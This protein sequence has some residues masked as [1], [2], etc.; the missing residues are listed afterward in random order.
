MDHQRKRM[1][2]EI[3]FDFNPKEKWDF[4]FEKLREYY[5]KHGHCELFWAGDCLTFIL[6]TPTK[7]PPVPLPGFQAMFHE[8]ARKPLNW[9]NG[10]ARNVHASK[11]AKWIRNELESSK[12]LVSISQIA[13][14]R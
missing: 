2:D 7:T 12:K 13:R 1:L 9:A 10:S 4:H 14:T 5:E 3:N 6:N 8:S 11:M